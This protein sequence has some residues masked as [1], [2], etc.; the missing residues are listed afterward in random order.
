MLLLIILLVLFNVSL[1]RKVLN[2]K[3]TYE[4]LVRN[5]Q[6]VTN[7]ILSIK[8]SDNEVMKNIKILEGRV[9]LIKMQYRE[10][11]KQRKLAKMELEANYRELAE[12]CAGLKYNLIKIP[13]LMH[14]IEDLEEEVYFKEVKHR[15]II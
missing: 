4:R 2:Q 13:F 3:R 10:V 1:A 14:C 5:S 6:R 9:D 15:V 12:M 8:N 11:S 7:S